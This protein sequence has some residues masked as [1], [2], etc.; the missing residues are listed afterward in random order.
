M[1]K[2]GFLFTVTI[3]LILT[4]ILLSISVW[5]KSVEASERGYS[6]FYK[7]STVEL[8]IDQITPARLDNVTYVIMNRE[9]LRLNDHSIDNPVR[10][11]SSDDPYKNIRDASF[12]LLMDGNASPVHFSGDGMPTEEQ[13]S[14]SAWASNLNASLRSI[15]VYLNE[16]TVSHFNINQSGVDKVNYSFDVSLSMRDYTNTASVTRSYH[17]A[18]NVSISGFVDPALARASKNK[19]GDSETI[20]R[21]FFFDKGFQSSGF[22]VSRLTQGSGGQGWVYGPLVRVSAIST[23]NPSE[24]R[25][26]ILVGSYDEIRTLDSHDQ[27]AGFILT[28]SPGSTITCTSTEGVS[29]TTE[30]DT[31]NPIVYY[32]QT[33]KDPITKEDLVICVPGTDASAWTWKPFMVVSGFN[34]TNAPTCPMLNGSIGVGNCAL[35]QNGYKS[36]QVWSNILL[37]QPTSLSGLYDI[38]SVRDFTMCGFYTQNQ[39]APTYLQRLLSN[40]YG[41]HGGELGIETFVIGNYAN[42][43]DVYGPNPNGVSSRL[44]RQLFDSSKKGV[45]IRGLPGCKTFETCSDDPQTGVFAI[46]NPADYGLGSI[47]CDNGAAGCD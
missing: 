30:T 8:A 21:E 35:L 34:P 26:Y 18:N 27:F 36:S 4:Y 17:I 19:A 14:F 44:D 45:K 41:K 31:F 39:N 37:K 28:N 22:S 32:S 1:D 11:G 38:E 15:G 25:N 23:V 46:Y 16:F 24:Y 7:E 43:K 33:I 2:R 13:S 9:L 40:S 29:P 3:F 12:E 10:E 20:Y 5:V 47:A 42:D 6:E